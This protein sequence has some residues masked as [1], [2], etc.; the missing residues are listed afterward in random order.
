MIRDSD[1]YFNVSVESWR[2]KY[3]ALYMFGRREQI[4]GNPLDNKARK[5]AQEIATSDRKSI[6]KKR[7]I[8][9]AKPLELNPI[10]TEFRSRKGRTGL[11]VTAGAQALRRC[12]PAHSFV[13]PSAESGA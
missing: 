2:D 9:Q 4:G 3:A 7:S 5:L 8:P 13:G 10:E 12:F 1:K 11:E 6:T